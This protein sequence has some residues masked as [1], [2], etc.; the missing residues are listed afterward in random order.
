MTGGAQARD[1]QR[2]RLSVLHADEPAPRLAI[3][4]LN[5]AGSQLDRQPA[6]SP[7]SEFV[8]RAPRGC[9]IG[10]QLAPLVIRKLRMLL[11]FFPL[12]EQS[13]QGACAFQL[14]ASGKLAD[15]NHDVAEF[16]NDYRPISH[17]I[18][19]EILEPF[20]LQLGV[21]HGVHDVLVPEVVLQ[22]ARVLPDVRQ[23]VPGRAPQHV[24]VDRERQTR[25]DTE[26]RE[27]LSE[28]GIGAPRIV[29]NTKGPASS[30]RFSARSSSPPIWCTL[31]FPFLSRRPS[32]SSSAT[33]PR[34]ASPPIRV[35]PPSREYD[36]IGSRGVTAC[37]RTTVPVQPASD[38]RSFR[39]F[40]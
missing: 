33:E 34:K 7:L 31:G 12:V 29:M 5:S 35:A 38:Q 4:A 26:P 8:A 18:L 19:R 27:K 32:R 17:S 1:M 25:L 16:F 13:P 24:H 40:R 36:T 28:P 37:D 22:G 23:L 3:E 9:A 2:R 6:L 11:A 30:S 15:E 10:L 20:G 39:C 14:L 21:A